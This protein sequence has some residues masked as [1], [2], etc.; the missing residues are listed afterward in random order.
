MTAS[1]KIKKAVIQYLS[2][3]GLDEAITIA[4]ADSRAELALPVL[5]VN[6]S[7]MEAHSTA[8]SMV[9]MAEVEMTLRSHTGDNTE[10]DVLAW[11]D[12]IESALH[13]SSALAAV[14][15]DASLRVYEWTY[16]GSTTEWDESTSEVMF[17]ASVL[18][19]REG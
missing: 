4:D 18:V 9:H 8:L 5:A 12:R 11:A 2:D 1:Q 14:F 10:D 7:S 17:T 15:T 6:I 3:C 13:D 19:Q 16:G